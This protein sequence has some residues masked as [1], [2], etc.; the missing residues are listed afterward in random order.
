MMGITTQRFSAR[1]VY[2]IAIAGNTRAVQVF[3]SMG[4]ALGVA[5]ANL[6]NLFNFP[7]Y[8]LSGGPLPAWDLFAPTMFAE[9]RKR[10][11]TFDRTGARVEKAVLGADAGLLGAAYLPFQ[12]IQQQQIAAIK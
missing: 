12:H 5:I 9:I 2:E 11:F 6:V 1:E 7:L 8:L 10:S 3:E 4:R